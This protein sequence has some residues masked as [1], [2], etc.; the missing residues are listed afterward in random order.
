LDVEQLRQKLAQEFKLPNLFIPSPD[1]FL[2]VDELPLLG[3]GKLDLKGIKTVAE[4][5]LAG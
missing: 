3:T 5:M 4:E 1:S 2:L